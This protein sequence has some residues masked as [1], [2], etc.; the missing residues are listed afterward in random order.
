M[1]AAATPH[2]GGSVGRYTE[3]ADVRFDSMRVRD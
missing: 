2:L 1:L 3:D